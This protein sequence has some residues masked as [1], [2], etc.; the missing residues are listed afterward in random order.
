MITTRQG[1]GLAGV[2]LLLVAAAG[3]GQATATSSTDTSQPA[4]TQAAQVTLKGIMM[5]QA[6]CQ[7][8]DNN[9]A[10]AKVLVLFAVEGT[11]EVAAIVDGLMAKY[12]PGQSMDGDQAR[13]LLQGFE[14]NLK[15]Y[16]AP[17]ELAEKNL[18]AGR[19]RNPPMAVT[20]EIYWKDGRKWIAPTSIEPAKLNYPAKMLAPDMPL[21][22]PAKQPLVLKVGDDLSLKCILL[23]AGKFLAGDPFYLDPRWD[24]TYP[25]MQTLTRPFYLAEIPVTQEMYRAVMGPTTN[26]SSSAAIDPKLPVRDIP[27]AD[28]QK[29]CKIL[30]ETNGVSVRLPTVA[31]WEYAARVGTSNPPFPQKYKD[32]NSSG[33][34]RSPLP[35]KSKEPNA[36]GL[37][38][39]ASCWYEVTCDRQV[40]SRSDAIDQ[41][42]PTDAYEKTGKT[43]SLW[44]K[45]VVGDYTVGNHEGVG[46]DGKC[47]VGTKFRI[48]VDAP[49]AAPASGPTTRATR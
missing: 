48:A 32:Q 38:D 18:K 14:K 9:P 22:M 37:Y 49:M 12:F 5:T 3:L 44:G 24:D 8:R 46:S 27:F 40:F 10:D 31:Q 34:N 6:S 7:P 17:G 39:M 43:F 20:G 21:A 2:L 23:P 26:P 15:F 42:F 13:G 4:A 41:R 11:P 28:I 45:G 29:F 35:V 30:S 16:I 33:P 47:Y 19:W 25:A 1:L 36:W